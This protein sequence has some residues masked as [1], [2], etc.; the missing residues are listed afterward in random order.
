MT[1]R[2]SLFPRN[3]PASPCGSR[4]CGGNTGS[5]SANSNVENNLAKLCSYFLIRIGRESSFSAF[6][7]PTR[8]D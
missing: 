7:P 3:L 5:K 6:D 4:I 1:G 8:H 2:K